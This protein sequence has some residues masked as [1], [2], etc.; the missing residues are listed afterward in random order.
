MKYRIFTVIFICFLACKQ[1]EKPITKI[2]KPILDRLG[3]LKIG[4]SIKDFESKNLKYKERKNDGLCIGYDIKNIEVNEK[5]TLKKVYVEFHNTK[6]AY[7]GTECNDD[8]MSF[9]KSRFG[10]KG[11]NITT[12]TE[13]IFCGIEKVN[14]KCVIGLYQKNWRFDY[15]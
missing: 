2:E 6:L 9:L 3:L 15:N 4:M 8:F 12:N 1:T 13:E 7:I 5:I 11:D 14:S 10:R